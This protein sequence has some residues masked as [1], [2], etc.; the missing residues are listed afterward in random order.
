MRVATIGPRLLLLVLVSTAGCKRRKGDEPTPGPVAAAVMDAAVAAPR[1]YRVLVTSIQISTV[2]PAHKRE[3][4][5]RLLAK[6]LAAQLEVS[7]RFALSTKEVP[8]ALRAQPGVLELL[9][10]YDVIDQG[11]G[12][13]SAF[14][15]VEARMRWARSGVALRLRERIVTERPLT[16]ADLKNLDGVVAAHVEMS[17]ATMGKALV[18]REVL[19]TAPP[20]QVIAALDAGDAARTLWALELVGARKLRGAHDALVALLG[21]GDHDVRDGAISALVALGDPKGVDPLTKAASLG[22]I[23]LLRSIIEA[24]SVLGGTDAEVYLEFVASGHEDEDIKK[25]AADA[26]RRVRL[27]SGSRK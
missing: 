16:P 23:T 12:K 17:V 3:I 15:T 18:E 6:K 7:G 26:L 24:V 22:D 19:R 14:A 8:R 13:K 20:A 10:G 2:E 1:D 25:L 5:P 27:R 11:G 9:I 21:S 4:Y